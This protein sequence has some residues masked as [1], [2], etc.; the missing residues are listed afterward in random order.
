MLDKILKAQAN[1]QAT[2][3]SKDGYPLLNP[4]EY[5]KYT[6]GEIYQFIQQMK[7]CLAEELTELMEALGDNSRDIHKPWAKNYKAIHESPMI[8]SAA[9]KEEAIDSLCFLLNILLAVG[10]TPEN[11]DYEYSK[12]LKKNTTRAAQHNDR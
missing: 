12:V 6:V 5:E 3:C 7:F 8:S 1:F 4:S 2:L 11:L 9:I 10:I